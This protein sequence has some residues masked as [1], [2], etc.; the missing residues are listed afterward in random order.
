MS[1]VE[2]PFIRI[3]DAAGKEAAR[4]RPPGRRPRARP[5]RVSTAPGVLD[6]EWVRGSTA[7]VDSSTANRD[8]DERSGRARPRSLRFVSLGVGIE[9]EASRRAHLEWIRSRLD[10]LLAGHVEPVD[11]RPVQHSFAVLAGQDG[12]VSLVL[13]GEEIGSSRSET[14]ALQYLGA[15]IKLA[16]GA[17]TRSHVVVHAGVVGID[18]SAIVLPAHSFQGKTTLVRELISRGA[19]YYSDDLALFD[20][21]GMVHPFPKTLSLRGIAGEYEQVEHSAESLGGITGKAPLRAGLVVFTSFDPDADWNPREISPGHALLR[22]TE[23]TLNVRAN[24]RMTL[25]VLSGVVN[26]GAVLWESKRRDATEVA[27]RIL[28]RARR[29][30][31]RRSS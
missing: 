21:R 24:P 8:S 17:S 2:G 30:A 31:I 4:S 19:A 5:W 25:D 26:G 23:H 6:L 14:V 7:A 1:N 28:D 16:V 9:V 20:R 11:G 12:S 10:A 29:V 15:R 18:E 27:D 22:L 13:D 3:T